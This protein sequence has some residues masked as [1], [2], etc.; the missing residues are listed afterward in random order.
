MAPPLSTLPSR[1]SF[2]S[3]NRNRNA[4]LPPAFALVVGG[5]TPRR[6]MRG[7]QVLLMSGG[8]SGGDFSPVRVTEVYNLRKRP[9]C[10]RTPD[11]T[12]SRATG[13]RPQVCKAVSHTTCCQAS[14]VTRPAS[15]A[16]ASLIYSPCSP[17]DSVACGGRGLDAQCCSFLTLMPMPRQTCSTLCQ[18]CSACS[19]ACTGDILTVG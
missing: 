13:E 6:D 16:S 1:A 17:I 14:V 9:A 2:P 7:V 19:R 5:A 8:R 18:C 4:H 12:G 15:N 10:T 3:S 11:L